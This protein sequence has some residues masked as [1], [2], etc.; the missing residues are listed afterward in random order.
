MADQWSALGGQQSEEYRGVE[1]WSCRR[2]TARQCH[3][4]R[5]LAAFIVARHPTSL[6]A[7]LAATGQA[8][9]WTGGRRSAVGRVT[10]EYERSAL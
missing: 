8:E 6:S 10:R 1:A 4:R 2:R 7:I 3:T 9:W 5:R